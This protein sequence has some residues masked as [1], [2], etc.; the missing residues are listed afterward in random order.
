M[1]HNRN[2]VTHSLYSSIHLSL[3]RGYS[4]SLKRPVIS[5]QNVS[6]GLERL[7]LQL[8]VQD[9]CSENSGW[10]SSPSAASSRRSLWR[11]QNTFSH[12]IFNTSKHQLMNLHKG[13]I[14]HSKQQDEFYFLFLLICISPLIHIHSPAALLDT[15]YIAYAQISLYTACRNTGR[16][17]LSLIKVDWYLI[18]SA[19]QSDWLCSPALWLSGDT[20]EVDPKSQTHIPGETR[21]ICCLTND[22]TQP[23]T[24]PY[25]LWIWNM[26]FTALH[27]QKIQWHKSPW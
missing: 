11:K 27:L 2:S 19:D 9:Q 22:T 4:L 8:Q 23:Y 24:S 18:S 16:T 15:P 6:I 20:T 1:T 12:S 5:D 3:D 25:H 26:F 21:D 17:E 13:R 10:G 7:K 14:C